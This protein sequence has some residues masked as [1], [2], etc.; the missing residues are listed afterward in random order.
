MSTLDESDL[1][2]AGVHNFYTTPTPGRVV[3]TCLNLFTTSVLTYCFGMAHNP[4]GR[5]GCLTD[6]I[7]RDACRL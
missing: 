5:A 1:R 6:S 7:Q 3:T 4:R 2:T